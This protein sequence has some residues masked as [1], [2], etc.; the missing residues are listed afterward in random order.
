M[1]TIDLNADLG[2]GFG[3]RTMGDDEATLALVSSAN[4]ACGGHAGDP[5]TMYA[6]CTVAAANGVVVGAH[7]SY[8][9]RAGFGRRVI[10]MSPTEIGHAVIAQVGALV[11]IARA[12]GTEVRYVKPHGALGNVA[13]ADDAVAVGVVDAV[14]AAFPSLAIL[15]ISGTC[16]EHAARAAG[17]AVYSEIFADRGYRPDG[18]LVPR[19]QPGAMIHD[20]D[21]ATRRLLDFI[22]HGRMPVVG[23]APIELDAHSIC[24]HGDS[25]GA[26]EMARQIRT[27]L[28]AAGLPPTSFLGR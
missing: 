4:V 21:V 20:P 10:P 9:D 24:V 12:A 15:A 22:E 13:A 17:V 7:P 16:L 5:E 25:P 23:G 19:G 11:G 28:V 8:P 14:R 2:E 26:V 6:T 3:P 1:R 18:L 27:G